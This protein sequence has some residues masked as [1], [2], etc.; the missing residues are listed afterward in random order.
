MERTIRP[1]VIGRSN[2]LF[3]ETPRGAHATAAL[4]SLVE[5]ATANGLVFRKQRV[6]YCAYC[7]I[8]AT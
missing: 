7:D 4:Y 1:F 6:T 3:S 8:L 2:W 5:T